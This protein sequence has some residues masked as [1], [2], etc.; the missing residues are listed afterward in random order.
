M[1]SSLADWL[2]TSYADQQFD[3]ELSESNFGIDATENQ[4]SS[5]TQKAVLGTAH[6]YSHD[7]GY[8]T[9]FY[10]PSSPWSTGACSIHSRIQSPPSLLAIP[11][12][13]YTYHEYGTSATLPTTF[14]RTSYFNTS[15]ANSTGLYGH[16][17]ESDNTAPLDWRCNVRRALEQQKE[18]LS[19]SMEVNS[20]DS[21]DITHVSGFHGSFSPC[22]ALGATRASWSTSESSGKP[23]YHSTDH[24]HCAQQKVAVY[25]DGHGE[26][27]LGGS[28]ETSQVWRHE[29][30]LE[31]FITDRPI[32][33]G[34]LSTSDSS[35][36]S[37]SPIL[38]IST[39]PVLALDW[40]CS[41]C[42]KVLATK[43]AKNLNRNKRRHDCR[44]TG[45]KCTCNECP[46][47][48]SRSDT[49]LN[50]RRKCHPES[51]TISRRSRKRN[52]YNRK[53]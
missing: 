4:P 28:L 41:D 31:A 13:E 10:D 33:V 45:P 25:M 34:S 12:T 48:Y 51:P 22:H 42:G 18:E 38:T 40:T 37:P 5:T 26:G 50:H 8:S 52:T 21:H 44:R 1:A 27:L 32:C 39:G 11:N 49:L 9:P 17:W 6:S 7:G 20:Y 23:Y 46:K 14:H 15:G 30:Q 29:R 24:Y 47:S 36:T 43:G 35:L 2:M 19:S 16:Q 3:Y 53:R